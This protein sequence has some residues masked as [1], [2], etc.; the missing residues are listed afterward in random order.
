MNE[1]IKNLLVGVE[2]EGPSD[3][4]SDPLAVGVC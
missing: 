1:R 3:G 2:T 4:V